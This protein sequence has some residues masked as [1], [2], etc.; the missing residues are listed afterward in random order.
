MEQGK[1][2]NGD[3]DRMTS[4]V[5]CVFK[6]TPLANGEIKELKVLFDNALDADDYTTK[7]QY[8]YVDNDDNYVVERW[9]VNNTAWNQESTMIDNQGKIHYLDA[10][11]C[12]DESGRLK[13]D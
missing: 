9:E 3:F 7:H 12:K 4:Y 13:N 1:E 5:W 6:E 11:C 2:N 10:H 8:P